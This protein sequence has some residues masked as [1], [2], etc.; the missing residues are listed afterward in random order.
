MAKRRLPRSMIPIVRAGTAF[1][2]DEG[3]VLAGHLA[4]VGLLS[5]VPFLLF[6]VALAS[7]FGATEPGTY[8]V[9][10]L[11]ENMPGA[12]AATFEP[13][14]ID[15]FQDEREDLLTVSLVTMVWMAGSGLEGV[16]RAVNRAYGA[17]ETRPYWR[18]R[19][20]GMVIVVAVSGLIVLVAV[21]L[22][23]GPMVWRAASDFLGL[24][25]EAELAWRVA[26]YA[27]GG[28]VLFAITALFYYLLP[29]RRPSWRG[30]LPGAAATLL[31]SLALSVVFSLY[32]GDGG[33]Y[34]SVYGGLG[35]VI[36]VLV[37]FYLLGAIFVLGAELN[38]AV[39]AL[40]EEPPGA[41]LQG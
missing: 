39:D 6:V 14:I 13:A 24:G 20:Q 31:L 29:A 11:L 30:V 7:V 17:V 37:F 2:A 23:F 35:G 40:R 36:A 28:G 26:R 15:V 19:V 41:D 18:R 21:C 1:V 12:V 3:P 38:A 22:F 10:F 33:P 34:E 8:F 9:A 4:F 16:R 5:L 32:V 27:V 25:A